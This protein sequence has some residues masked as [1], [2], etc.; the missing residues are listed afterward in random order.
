MLIIGNEDTRKVLS[1]KVCMD[2][3]EAVFNDL[4]KGDADYLP[5]MDIYSPCERPDG[6][7]RWSASEGASRRLGT[8]AMRIKSDI[9][10]WPKGKTVEWYSVKPGTYCGLIYLYSTSTAE[11]LAILQD[12]IIQHMRSG[13]S[14][15]L[16]A[17]L[18]ARPDA[19][20]VGLL[21]SG[22]M[23]RT[24][25][26]AFCEVRK[27]SRVRVYSP[28]PEHRNKFAREMSQAL[29]LSCEPVDQPELVFRGADIVATCTDSMVP[30]VKA[31]WLEPG[32]HLTDCKP[33]EIDEDVVKHCDIKMRLG[34]ARAGKGGAALNAV[35]QYTGAVIGRP[36]EVARIPKVKARDWGGMP[37]LT[38]FL[39][40]QMA[41]RTSPSQITYFANDGNQGL[42][43]VSVATKVYE[44]VKAQGL[45]TN[46]P[47]ELILENIRD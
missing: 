46:I 22:E 18:L 47:S 40:N 16:G 7:Y 3:L 42:Q 34:A 35:G 19:T 32:M 24:Y 4:A 30:T 12:G 33:E 26:E 9:V 38:D 8:L 28:T 44:L 36:E 6:Y 15:G 31:S 25:L 11:L 1:M 39:T 29:K 27:I 2:E 20:S 21:G 17:K 45:G 13:G 10:Y 14:A 43:F 41:G 5:R 23:A 37:S